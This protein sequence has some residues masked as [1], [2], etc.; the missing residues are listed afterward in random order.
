VHFHQQPKHPQAFNQTPAKMS[1]RLFNWP[2]N[3]LWDV[4]PIFSHASAPALPSLGAVDVSETPAE[5]AIVADAPGM[6]SSDIKVEVKGH[7]LSISGERKEEH[8]E[9]SEDK[10]FYRMERSQSSFSRS[11]R[12]PPTADASQ[13]KASC[14]D[15]VLKVVVPKKPAEADGVRVAVA[16]SHWSFDAL[17]SVCFNHGWSSRQTEMN[18]FLL[19]WELRLDPELLWAMSLVAKGEPKKHSKENGECKDNSDI[20]PLKEMIWM[21]TL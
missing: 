9:E 10:K 21:N 14:Q 4:A 19:K 3:D 16:S 12:L 15:G 2:T 5:F 20:A 17:L 6:T 18:P 11:F 13:I 8:R 1:L 7:T